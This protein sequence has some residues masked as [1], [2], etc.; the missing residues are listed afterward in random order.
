MTTAPKNKKKK[1]VGFKVRENACIWMKAGV[2]NFHICDN[3]YD[4]NT[5]PFDDAMQRAMRVRKNRRPN[6]SEALRK[7]YGGDSLPCRHVLTGRIEASKLCTNNYECDHC[8]FDQ[9]LE[10][11]DIRTVSGPTVQ[12]ASGY[13]VAEDYYYHMGH[14][15]VR[16][17]H[18]GYVR[19]GLDDFAVKLFGKL[20]S[21]RIPKI[22]APLEQ[23]EPG[24][25]F[26]RDELAA[27]VMSP[28]AGTVLA[29]NHK[30]IDLPEVI[31]RSPYSE[32][33]LFLMDPK[34]LKSNLKK[35]YF[36]EEV[37]DWL[38]KENR[39]LMRL[40]GPEYEQLAATGGQPL[41][42]FYGSYPEIGW[43]HLVRAFL[44]T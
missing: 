44:R 16:V 9:W 28:I 17:E 33:W 10:E 37:V 20:Q 32:G 2:I 24:W 42:D 11:T 21:V 31:H 40:M 36:G 39:R 5:C 18:G 35:L 23:H 30:A 7:Q 6:W 26:S 14:G 8:E 41:D 19:V 1:V 27:E 22:G 15:W 13:R 12:E 29:V 38:D 4:C 3:A 43:E 25:A 34:M